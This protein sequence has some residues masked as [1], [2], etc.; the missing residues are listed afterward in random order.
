MELEAT[1]PQRKKTRFAL[2]DSS[3]ELSNEVV[4]QYYYNI[5]SIHAELRKGALV[6]RIRREAR[7]DANLLMSGPDTASKW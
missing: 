4:L 7:Q 6:E 2:S 1:V 5:A 3:I